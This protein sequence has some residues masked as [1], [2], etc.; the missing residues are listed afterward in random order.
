MAQC[1]IQIGRINTLAFSGLG[2]AR[3]N[4]LSDARSILLSDSELWQIFPPN[5]RHYT[6]T[7]ETQSKFPFLKV[8]AICVYTTGRV[9]VNPQ[10]S[11]SKDIQRASFSPIDQSKSSLLNWVGELYSAQTIAH[12]QIHQEQKKLLLRSRDVIL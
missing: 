10:P 11:T 7:A 12:N 8:N 3:E 9:R 2:Y 4:I 5:S 1:C 6:T